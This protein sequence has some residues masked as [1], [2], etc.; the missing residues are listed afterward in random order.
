MFLQKSDLKNNIY[1]YQVE[2]ITEGDDAIVFQALQA[3]EDE[4]RS[5]LAANNKKEW[6]DGRL[7]YDLDKIFSATGTER[8]ALILS[9]CIII[10]KW[11]I[12]D[13][14]NVDIIYEKAK[15]RYDR[16]IKYLN[17]LA[18]GDISLDSLPQIKPPV[19]PDENENTDDTYPFM[20]GSREK[21][22]Y[23]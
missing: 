15:E 2:D 18:K 20:Y 3:A 17:Q 8:S 6:Q 4:C 13:L 22:N 9:H 21:F 12:I 7:K 16:T 1:E 11:H 5:Y 14:A 19:N 23:E 10:A